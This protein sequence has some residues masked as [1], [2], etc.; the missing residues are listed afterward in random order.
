[1]WVEELEARVAALEAKQER[2]DPDPE[3]GD[4]VD[5][6]DDHF[7]ALLVSLQNLDEAIAAMTEERLKLLGRLR[8]YLIY[9]EGR[10]AQSSDE[11]L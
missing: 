11:P 8:P 10:R 3:P 4:E 1:M 9:R 6:D 7:P 5:G 2:Q